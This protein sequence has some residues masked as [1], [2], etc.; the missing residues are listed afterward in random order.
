MNLIQWVAIQTVV[1]YSFHNFIISGGPA[2][3][4][5]Y[6]VPENTGGT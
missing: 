3:I 2:K 1:L 4:N 6:Q 5:A